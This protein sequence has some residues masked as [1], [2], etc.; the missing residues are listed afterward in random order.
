MNS[1]VINK[2][3]SS[4]GV[5]LD[6]SKNYLEFEGE[7]RPENVKA[8]FLPII[9]WIDNYGK[10]LMTL[11]TS[12]QETVIK[13]VFKLEYFNSSSAKCIVDVILALQAIQ[14][15]LSSVKLIIDWLYPSDDDDLLDSGQEIVKFT[16]VEMN[17]IEK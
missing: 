11:N 15:N 8:F 1:I 12:S 3:D 17:F 4:L 5:I 10:E 9:D 6:A 2:T 16:G 7:S 14:N 13:I